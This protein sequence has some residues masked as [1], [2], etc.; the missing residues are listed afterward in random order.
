[1]DEIMGK[2]KER[3][4]EREQRQEEIERQSERRREAGKVM[5]DLAPTNLAEVISVM[6]HEESSKDVDE[7]QDGDD[8]ENMASAICLLVLP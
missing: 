7:G 8:P 5:E 3:E 4:R 1:M 6:G 2:G